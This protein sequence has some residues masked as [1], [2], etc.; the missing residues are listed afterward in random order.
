[1]LE[2]VGALWRRLAL[3]LALCA[4]APAAL[5]AQAE[6]AVGERD[7]HGFYLLSFDR[8]GQLSSP[9]ERDLAIAELRDNPEVERI[10]V[11]AYGWDN[12][13]GTSLA[14]YDELRALLQPPGKESSTAI[15]GIAWDS[16]Q[17]GIRKLLSDLVPLPLLADA[18][19]RIPDRLLFPLSFWSKSAMADRIG[20]GG[21]RATLNEIFA[22]AYPE[23]AL[24][25]PLYMVGHSFG[26]R[27]LAALL[28]REIGG[29]LSVRAQ[30]FRSLEQ[31]RGA[32]LIQPA[33]VAANLPP[34]TPFPIVV[35]QSEHDHA[36][37]M[38][39]PLANL[40]VN[41]YAFTTAEALLEQR[42]DA[43]EDRVRDTASDAAR[44]T[45]TLL[46]RPRRPPPAAGKPATGKDPEGGPPNPIELAGSVYRATRRTGTELLSI[47]GSIAFS[48]AVA[49]LYYADAQWRGLRR[50]PLEHLLDTLA[51]LPGIEAL[52][53]AADHFAGRAVP[54]GRRS[55][56]LLSLGAL[57]ES[58]G[59]L[60]APGLLAPSGPVYGPQLAPELGSAGC[61]LPR[62]SGLLLVDV[63][64][65][66][67][68]SLFGDLRRPWLDYTL[69][70]LDLIGAHSAYTDPELAAFLTRLFHAL[71]SGPAPA[72]AAAGGTP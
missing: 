13:G 42:V 22:A 55:K 33:L 19:A 24:H 45:G 23:P 4:A 67:G 64:E 71:P 3:V 26:A 9:Y 69:G 56:G 66:S 62:C 15:I 20:Y 25:P 30:E 48:L 8:Y 50:A 65:L 59:R 6:A 14:S 7:F 43:V 11:V 49:P 53:G 57:H 17:T 38:L 35:T 39:F 29:I 12:D 61:G 28:K 54:S 18:A 41:A 51:Q 52:V 16:S 10:A 21:L 37:G 1:M 27:V 70:W 34:D 60:A 58:S 40:A 2:A 36:L 68:S 32:L 31:V 72:A 47:P 63:S 5:G 44:R 46:G